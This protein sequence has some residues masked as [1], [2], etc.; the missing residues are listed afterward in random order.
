MAKAVPLFFYTFRRPPAWRAAE[1]IPGS[2]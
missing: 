1:R 2:D